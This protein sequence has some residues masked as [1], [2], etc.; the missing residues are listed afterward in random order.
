MGNQFQST[1]TV[2]VVVVVLED[3]RWT[4]ELIDSLLQFTNQAKTK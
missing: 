1:K 3:F 4:L 2:V